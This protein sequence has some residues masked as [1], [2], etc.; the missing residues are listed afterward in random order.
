MSL[1]TMAH[2]VNFRSVKYGVVWM[3]TAALLTPLP[4]ALAKILGQ[5]YAMSASEIAFA[6][7]VFQTIT[8]FPAII[9]VNGVAG[10][11]ARCLWLNLVRGG[12]MAVAS[13]AFF[14]ALRLMPLAD[15]IAIFFVQPMI[16]T[17]L[18]ILFLREAF[19][20]RRIIAVFCGFAGA[21]LVIQPNVVILGGVALLPLVCALFFAIYLVLGRHLSKVESSLTMHLYTGLGGAFSLLAV[22]L[23]GGLSGL[24]EFDFVLPTGGHIWML[25]VVMSLLAS[26][27]HL[28]YI[29]AYR[30]APA[31]LLAPIGYFEI[32]SAAI[33]G[34][35]MF[36]DFPDA[37]KGL[38]M[39]I[40]VASGL[41]LVW[42]D[43]HTR[44]SA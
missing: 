5:D 12:L 11:R 37:L 20:L 23:L 24:A 35:L 15:A 40:I 14:V 39:V 7:F 26:L 34:F 3:I 13:V 32:V 30:L 29:H 18:S 42:N 33:L 2:A 16:V 19:D 38:G 9:V 25:V 22:L 43:R 27:V 36:G 6:R 10:L 31:G 28:M 1:P 17:V 4:D 41:W 8:V 44:K 21:L